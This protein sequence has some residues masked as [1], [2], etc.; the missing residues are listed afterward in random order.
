M[1]NILV[2]LF[3]FAALVIFIYCLFGRFFVK[4]NTLPLI[5]GE[6]AI[7]LL[8]KMHTAEKKFSLK[9]DSMKQVNNELNQRITKNRTSLFTIKEENSSLKQTIDDLLSIHFSETDTASY[10]AN[11]DSLASALVNLQ[12]INNSK[13][14]LYDGM[15]TDYDLQLS[16]KDSMISLQQDQYDSLRG[17]LLGTLQQNQQLASENANQKE[18]IK[19]H[20]RGK[21]LLG[22]ILVAV[23][24]IFAV[25]VV[26]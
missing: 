15:I 17:S 16:I 11:C 9:L 1:K 12:E 13:D 10:Y 24:G 5:K 26:H 2:I 18:I 23:V 4:D 21:H 22:G 8:D 6:D 25:H 14:S 3:V 20:K 19:R 7:A